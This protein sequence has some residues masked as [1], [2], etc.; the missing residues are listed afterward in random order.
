MNSPVLSLVVVGNVL[1][2]TVSGT[3]QLTLRTSASWPYQLDYSSVAF[4]SFVSTLP[5]GQ[6]PTG[7]SAA[8]SQDTSVSLSCSS[9]KT[10]LC[11]QQFLVTVNQGAAEN[12]DIEGDYSFASTLTC[13]DGAPCG[14]APSGAFSFSLL[15]V[16]M[17]FATNVDAT[18]NSVYILNAFQDPTHLLPAAS[19]SVGQFVY[20]DLTVVDPT[21][22]LKGI[23]FSDIRLIT[24]AGNDIIYSTAAGITAISDLGLT[25]QEV[26]TFLPPGTPADLSFS[27]QLLR[28][29][30]P[31]SLGL[32]QAGGNSVSISVEATINLVYYGDKKRQM[33][34][35]MELSQ[36]SAAKKILV[37][38]TEEVLA[39]NSP[40][41]T[42]PF[43]FTLALLSLVLF[44]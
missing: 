35:A 31:N 11:Y 38:A 26:N 37:V 12:C 44:Y 7:I 8:I 9:V 24:S 32:L 4:T 13:R 2:D 10:S 33:E 5:A 15:P 34:V 23:S 3:T 25:L 17:C 19:F 20:F 18:A 21:S 43:L 6:A 1:F 22:S 39:N 28:P 36:G 40:V 41:Y 27:F 29:L 16:D 30:L 14:G 42:V